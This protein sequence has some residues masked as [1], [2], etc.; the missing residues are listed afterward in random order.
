MLSRANRIT[1]A[2]HGV[3][4]MAQRQLSA[5]AATTLY[6]TTRGGQQGV[7]FD[8][9]VLQGLGHDGGLF[10]P[11]TIPTFS[12]EE[13]ESWRS[14]S[15][16][17]VAYK[18][19][20]LY[21]GPDMIPAAD[22]KDIIKRSYSTFRP[23]DAE[24]M[25]LPHSDDVNG[26]VTPTRPITD[27][28]HTLELYHGPTFAFKDV[29]LQFLGNLFE[30]LLKQRPGARITVLGA[31]SGDTG[32]S[33]IHGP[34][35]KKS[36][37]C[38]IMYPEGRTSRTQE[39]QMITVTDSNIH[40]IALG[41]TFDD[42]QAIVKASFNDKAFRDRNQLAAVNSINW[43]R[44]LAQQVYYVYAY[45]RVT[46]AGDAT[47][48]KKVS[49]TV[50][51]GNFGDILAGYYA[52]HM[53]LPVDQMVVATNRNDILD[54]FFTKGDYSL[55]PNGV[56]ETITPSMDIGISSNFERFLFHRLGENTDE[57][58]A[59]MKNFE[60]TGDLKP[61]KALLEA[62]RAEMDSA[63]VPDEEILT[64]I[65]DVYKEGNGYTLDPH[66][67]IGVAAARKA[68]KPNATDV[69]MIVLACAHW[70]K[71]PDA[72]KAA[73]G[74]EKAGKLTVPP[75]LAGLHKL[76][77]R[78]KSL[79]NGVPIVQGFVEETMAARAGTG[80]QAA[81]GKAQTA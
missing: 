73:L 51:T 64:T 18:V 66:S 27:G 8:E 30:H 70:A 3:L 76:E 78:V 56:A 55:S 65:A 25:H 42:C 41:G 54:R 28:M 2:R 47:A 57:M 19:M 36:I 45:L 71:F 35:G 15:Y 22:L 58:A 33:A 48:G 39:L 4:R 52:K 69:P 80:A 5:P 75:I 53:G 24:P 12:L 38:F 81:G 43:A 67:A 60:S 34:R 20:S 16:E 26:R 32:S 1:A 31:T 46:A 74:A 68:R 21:I 50:P 59:L 44:I 61:S 17:E 62:S 10:V 40:N 6:R 63:S 29:A 11:E 72:N 14:L 23:P 9:A 13:L 49:F 79:P 37:D 7:P 77:S